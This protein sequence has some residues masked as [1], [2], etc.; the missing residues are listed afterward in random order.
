MP[1]CYDRNM[2]LNIREMMPT[3]SSPTFLSASE[4]IH[5]C[6]LS[7]ANCKDRPAHRRTAGRYR[8]RR[9]GALRKWR[10]RGHRAPLPAICMSNVRSLCNKM[11]EVNLL[12]R[13]NKDFQRN[14]ALFFCE[15]WLNDDITDSALDLPGF[16]L[17]RADWDTAACGKSKGGGL[18]F[19]INNNW[20]VDA[21]KTRQHCC[22]ILESV[23]IECK[24]YYSPRE[25]SSVVLAG[26]YIPPQA[27]VREAQRLLAEQI[28][29]TENSRPNSVILVMGDFNSCNLSHELQS[30]KQLVTCA[31]RCGKTLDHFY[32]TIKHA[33]RSIPRAPLGHSDH[34]LIQMV[35]TYRQLLKR[36]KP[37]RT[38]VRRWTAEA[39]EM[40][41]DCMES[42][43]WESLRGPEDNNNTYAD[44]VCSYINFCEQ[45]CLPT[46]VITRYNNHKPWFSK[47]LRELRR[48]KEQAYR[49]GDLDTFRLA[50]QNLKK[51]IRSAKEEYKAKLERD[52]STNDPAAIWNTLRTLTNYNKKSPPTPPS[53]GLADDLNTFYTRYERP[54]VHPVHTDIPLPPSHSFPTL[55]MHNMKG[56]A[57]TPS[58]G[59]ADELHTSHTSTETSPLSLTTVPLAPPSTPLPLTITEKDVHKLFTRL[60]L[61][62]APGPDGVSPATLMHCA[63]QLAPVFTSIFNQS[64]SECSVPPCFKIS[65]IVPVPKKDRITCLND[66]RPV[67]LTSVVMKCFERLIL[68]FLKPITD[69]LLDPL[70]FA[71]RANRSVDDAV[72]LSLH[73]ILQHLDTP[74]TYVRALFVDFSSAFNTILPDRLHT[75]LLQLQV[76]HLICEWITDF[77]TNRKQQVRLGNHLSAPLTTN[78][79]APQGCVLSPYLFSLYTN[80]CTS[81]H[82]S[83][84][85]VKFADD[86]TVLGLIKDNDETAYRNTVSQL[87]AWCTDNN[88][89]LNTNKT[90]EMVMDFRKHPPPH[91]PLL[92]KDTIVKVVESV[93][94]L[95]TTITS[96]L[97][98]EIH[99]SNVIKRAQQRMF[100]LRLLR[101]MNISPK[102]RTQ[103]YRA[104]IE[105][106]LT[107]SI[108]V[109]YVASSA[110]T[111]Q[112]LERIVRTARRLTGQEQSPVS[113]LHDARVR[114][115]ASRIVADPSH[116]AHN[117]FRKLPSGHRFRS[118][119]TRTTRH[120]NSF[121]P[122]AITLLN[123]PS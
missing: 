17:I 76:P 107:S 29:T 69:P 106:V 7:V 119:S 50:R 55:I 25:F 58:P 46:K 33:Y 100:F 87:A 24:P 118:I 120:R 65:T 83:I 14:S 16:Q 90:V 85:L 48:H 88:L 117:L 102:I 122:K 47:Q 51:A 21:V 53:P 75:K 43:D 84:R 82:P 11:D 78:T 52:S 98:W 18:C 57:T 103:F 92:I 74:S 101:K 72:N 61:R 73:H 27:P 40:L 28:S 64:I 67:A 116:P 34:C 81:S 110:H 1:Y 96:D 99:S 108:T 23:F 105:S 111:K 12:L 113:V 20:C 71:Y 89:E 112:R 59:L 68:S 62:K 9:A 42:T 6:I 121:F 37:T 3:A 44:T 123:N 30:Y 56:H 80:D 66:Y 41:Q 93:K 95:G 91:P 31:T 13:T 45:M 22:S 114:K 79:G 19:Y 63:T 36:A 104:T 5:D 8:G 38:T 35:P 32:S 15:T 39:T 49:E 2:L 4:E 60:K 86:T 77:L 94:F 115:R 10:R 54:A 109:W 26:V 70:Q 97:K